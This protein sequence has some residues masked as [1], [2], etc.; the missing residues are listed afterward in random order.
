MT[1]M[2]P[3]LSTLC[4]MHLQVSATGHITA[5][6]PTMA[7][8][9]PHNP[10]QSARFLEVFTF[11]RPR[12]VKTFN[13]LMLHAGKQLDLAFRDAP[14]TRFRGVLE[15]DDNGGC[16]VNLSFGI[17]LVQAV[18]DYALTSRDFD[19]TDLAIEMLYL[20]EAKT[21]A[22]DAFRKQSKRLR[23]A[24]ETAEAQALADALTG[25]KNRR[26]L[27]HILERC[28]T[29]ER[30]F[31][32][33]HLDLDHFKQVNDIKGHAAGDHVLQ[34]AAD[35]MVLHVRGGDTVARIGG[36]EFILLLHNLTDPSAIGAIAGRLIDE[37]ERPI[38]YGDSPCRISASIGIAT[39]TGAQITDADSLISTADTALY[40]AK[41]AGRGQ[42]MFAT[43]P[44]ASQACDP[45]QDSP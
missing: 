24:Q 22:M 16:V 17:S 45:S 23:A 8:L 1:D 38:Q 10:L 19:P 42:F 44:P 13:D 25:L 34:Q 27:Y 31:S 40:A 32:L 39:F 15:R 5:V 18:Q 4:P 20:I 11:R 26:A 29:Q 30:P 21:A 36:D 3:I 12:D 43:D 7:R 6:G 33:L 2:T 41:R 28:L 14:H 9:R 35:R 37:L